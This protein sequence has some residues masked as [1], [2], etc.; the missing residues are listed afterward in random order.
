MNTINYAPII[1]GVLLVGSIAGFAFHYISGS[2]ATVIIA[3]AL[4]L[5][6]IHDSN[7]KLGRSLGAK[8]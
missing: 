4:S 8:R 7:I 2:D 1:G 5:L 6:G 3:L